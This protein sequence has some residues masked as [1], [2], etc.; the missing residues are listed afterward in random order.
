MPYGTSLSGFVDAIEHPTSAKAIDEKSKIC[1]PKDVLQGHFYLAAFRK[2]CEK[3]LGLCAR[4]RLEIY[5]Y[6]VAARESEAHRFRAIRPHKDMSTYD[7]QF[8]VHHEV[9]VGIGQRWLAGM[10]RNVFE[11]SNWPGEFGP[12]HNPVKRKRLFCSARKV[13]ISADTSHIIVPLFASDLPT[14]NSRLTTREIDTAAD[15]KI[16]AI[17]VPIA[18][19]PDS[20]VEND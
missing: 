17:T 11:A 14:L 3:T 10:R 20:V 15:V 7:R 6:V 13:K 5:G 16:G 4:V 9:F 12:E 2:G 18:M 8:N 1:A 19:Q